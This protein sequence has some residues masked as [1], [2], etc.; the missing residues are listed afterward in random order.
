MEHNIAGTPIGSEY[1]CVHCNE[2]LMTGAS[3][4]S[5]MNVM[6]VCYCLNPV[7][8]RYG[9]VTTVVVGPEREVPYGDSRDD[10][11]NN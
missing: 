6:V 4:S 5:D 1:R 11:Y 10:N 7:C 9:L 3:V 2:K 8:I